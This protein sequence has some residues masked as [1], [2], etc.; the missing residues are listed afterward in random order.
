VWP[1]LTLQLQ[2]AVELYTG[3]LC[4]CLV[5]ISLGVVLLIAPLFGSIGVNDIAF[6]LFFR[7][8]VPPH[9]LHK[10]C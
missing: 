8:P 6:C 7:M 9:S 4:E 1:W 2:P 10:K 5:P 3:W